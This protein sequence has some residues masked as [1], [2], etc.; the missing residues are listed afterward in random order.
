M[1]A[2]LIACVG[3]AVLIAVGIALNL[4]LY[5]R[6]YKGQP[7]RGERLFYPTPRTSTADSN[8]DLTDVD[9]VYSS[10]GI[11]VGLIVVLLVLG[12]TVIGAVINAIAR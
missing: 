10:R 8:L 11:L 2:F 9:M 3:I 5:T 6:L 4:Y 12:M 7:W 1:V